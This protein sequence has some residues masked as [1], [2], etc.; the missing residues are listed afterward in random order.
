MN[1]N[2]KRT[3]GTTM[4]LRLQAGSALKLTVVQGNSEGSE[5]IIDKAAVAGND[6]A[7]DICIEDPLV[8]LRHARFYKEGNWWVVKDMLSESGTFLND[9]LVKQSPIF[10]NSRLRIGNTVLLVDYVNEPE[11]ETVVVRRH[12]TWVELPAIIAHELKN[13]LQFFDAGV[14]QLKNDTEIVN[15]FSGELKS[16]EMAGERMQELV[17]ML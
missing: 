17:Q 7:T 5:F 1:I 16:F 13:Y 2:G 6:P 4:A 8:C 10:P 3:F 12:G 9:K 14:E 11:V 15:R